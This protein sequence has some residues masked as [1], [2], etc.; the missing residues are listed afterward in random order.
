MR[1]IKCL[2]FALIILSISTGCGKIANMQQKA[3]QLSGSGNYTEALELYE[4]ME[5]EKPKDPLILNDYGWTLFITDSLEA[6]SKKLES[7][8][9]A[10]NEGSSIL[11][12][13]IE[14]NLTI[15]NSYIKIK[16]HLCEGNSDQA[17]EVLDEIDRSWKAREM[18]LKHYALIHESMGNEGE[19]TKYWQRILNFYPDDGERNQFQK[20]ASSKIRQ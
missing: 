9:N 14:K 16:E 19:A 5:A 8:K 1:L 12:R 2:A 10:C 11:K 3:Y 18:R 15:T 7:A 13:N 4:K 20:L 17:K 6:A